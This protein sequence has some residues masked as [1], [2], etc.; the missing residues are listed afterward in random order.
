[1]TC[2]VT[3]PCI[4]C[5]FGDCVFAC[6]VGAFH[7]GP[8]FVV[9]NPAVCV[10]CTTCVIVCPVGAIVPDYEL[11]PDQRWFAEENARL[12]GVYPQADEPVTPLPDAEAWA[13]RTDKKAWLATPPGK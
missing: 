13:L 6:P 2:V 7:V 9:I 4:K 5:R 10:N 8:E 12:A 3:E 11:R 1:M